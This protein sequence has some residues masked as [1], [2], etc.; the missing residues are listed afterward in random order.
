MFGALVLPSSLLHRVNSTFDGCIRTHQGIPEVSEIARF[1]CVCINIRCGYGAIQK[2]TVSNCY[3]K[4]GRIAI[5]WRTHP[6]EN[7]AEHVLKTQFPDLGVE[8]RI[9]AAL[10]D[11]R[12]VDDGSAEVHHRGPASQRS[13][14]V[15]AG[16]PR[17][18]IEA[19]ALSNAHTRHELHDTAGPFPLSAALPQ[20]LDSRPE[21]PFSPGRPAAR[22][23]CTPRASYRAAGGFKS[24]QRIQRANW[25]ERERHQVRFP[26]GSASSISCA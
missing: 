2:A 5:R 6:Q 12:A 16:P 3:E 23:A 22:S 26:K 4:L 18:V 14:S 20:R 24:W 13:R 10:L 17:P 9:F 1:V 25:Q 21:M 7:R 15:Q 11:C 8:F 19:G